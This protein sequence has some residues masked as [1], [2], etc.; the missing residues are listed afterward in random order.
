L[1]ED[2]GVFSGFDEKGT[3]VRSRSWNYAGA[4]P[5]QNKPG[6][7]PA[8]PLMPEK[9]EFDP[10]LQ[11]PRCVFQLM[12]QHYSRYTPEMVEKVTGIH[13]RIRRACR[14]VYVDPRKGDMKKVATIIYA[15]DGRITRL[16]RRS[17]EPRRCCSCS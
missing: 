16:G 9:T 13:R 12:K 15:V 7:P 4:A 17:F 8:L 14:D 11:N 3:D 1:P 6:A 2:E 5:A 10:T